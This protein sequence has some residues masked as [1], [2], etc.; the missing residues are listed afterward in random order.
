M[1]IRLL[2]C[3]GRDFLDIDFV[4]KVLC[5]VHELYKIDTIIEGDA[6]GADRLAK[7]W[8]EEVIGPSESYPADWKRY[9]KQA[10]MLR[11]KQMLDQGMPD[12]VLAF[13][14]WKG[15]ANMIEQSRCVQHLPIWVINKILFRKEDPKLGY[16][17]NFDTRFPIIINNISWKSV[18][19]FYQAMKNEDLSYQNTV[20]RAP[21]PNK[22]KHLGNNVPLRTD[23]ENIKMNVMRIALEEKFKK[24]SEA[25]KLL[26]CTG[27][28][29]L[30]EYAPWR[31]SF[32]GM[33]YDPRGNL[34]G[35]NHLGK[36]LMERRYHLFGM[37][38]Y[39]Q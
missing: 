16:L 8:S 27:I 21:T 28:N 9:G 6:P 39:F 7:L 31:D 23:W 37:K 20:R 1:G 33:Y 13:P 32:W 4:T 5:T 30:I 15:T 29:Y 18:E 24:N 14:G 19:H 34:V 22:A 11:N 26:G 25:A 2:V 3:G 38:E 35:N 10:G 17:S 36:L 12:A